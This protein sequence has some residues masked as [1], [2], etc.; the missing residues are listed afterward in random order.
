MVS[1]SAH[2]LS[3][4]QLCQTKFL[5]RHD[6]TSNLQHMQMA[7]LAILVD[8]GPV[9]S[10]AQLPIQRWFAVASV[11]PRVRCLHTYASYAVVW[12]PLDHGGL[13]WSVCLRGQALAIPGVD[14]R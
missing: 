10:S 11:P 9:R 7:S 8:A 5:A 12:K 6:V 4:A 1:S 2:A 13:P 3:R 14:S